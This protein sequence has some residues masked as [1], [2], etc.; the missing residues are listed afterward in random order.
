MFTNFIFCLC[1]CHEVT[2]HD[3]IYVR[4]AEMGDHLTDI[5]TDEEILGGGKV[6]K[7]K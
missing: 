4:K 5:Q 6:G 7:Q 2:Y 3:L 1:E